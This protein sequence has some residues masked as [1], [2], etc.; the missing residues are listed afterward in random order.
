MNSSMSPFPMFVRILNPGWSGTVF[1]KEA[2][3]Q[4]QLVAY[5]EWVR[6]SLAIL[7]L[8]STCSSSSPAIGMFQGYCMSLTISLPHFCDDLSTLS[9]I[10]LGKWAKKVGRKHEE[11]W[12]RNRLL[13][14]DSK[15]ERMNS[16]NGHVTN[17]RELIRGKHA[18]VTYFQ[19]PR[20]KGPPRMHPALPWHN[21]R[22]NII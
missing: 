18:H 3:M 12:Q 20:G 2:G 7:H 5:R 16:G 10:C 6:H 9:R 22:C 1:L 15:E 19:S 11:N 8:H 13:A 21:S 17:C 14:V 4:V